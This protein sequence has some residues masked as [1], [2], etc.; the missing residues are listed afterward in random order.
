MIA[1]WRQWQA[2]D[3]RKETSGYMRM[4]DDNN[5]IARYSLCVYRILVPFV[6]WHVHKFAEPSE[7]EFN[8]YVYYSV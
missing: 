2:C 6:M 7:I 3:R 4:D 1:Q 5:I 8:E